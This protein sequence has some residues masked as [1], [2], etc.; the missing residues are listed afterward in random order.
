MSFIQNCNAVVDAMAKSILENKIKD[1]F[2]T[3]QAQTLP[4]GLNS[5][6]TF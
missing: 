3:K 2:K 6:K 5:T 4:S 1:E